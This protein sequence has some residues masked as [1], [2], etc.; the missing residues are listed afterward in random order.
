MFPI[1]RDPPGA[2][3]PHKLAQRFKI[4]YGFPYSWL[5]RPRVPVAFLIRKRRLIIAEYWLN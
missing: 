5:P 1:R 3:L 4:R 2:P